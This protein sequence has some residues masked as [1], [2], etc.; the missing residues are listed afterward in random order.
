MKKT[1]LNPAIV[2]FFLLL[3]IAFNFAAPARAGYISLNTALGSNIEGNALK[4]T[5]SSVNKGDKSAF[6]VQA[7]FRVGDKVV[8]A[9]KMA[10]LPV[11]AS[12]QTRTTLPVP[13]TKP[14]TYPL[15]LVM[16]YTDANQYPFSALTAQTFVFRKEAV[17][18]VFGRVNS[19]S[20]FKEG[21]LGF[22]LKN[23]GDREIAASTGLVAPREL[24]VKEEKIKLK[25]GPRSERSAGFTV[26][27]FSAL[28]GSTY[29]VFA[30]TEFED[31]GQHYTSVA[32][33]TIRV[34]E[35]K[36]FLGLSQ[37]IILI[38]LA[39]LVVIFVGAQFVRR[40]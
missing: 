37:N 19:T 18:P 21:R 8:L 22:K 29:Q 34:F 6:N 30:V 3:F 35:E 16:H 40:H 1:K 33:G 15:I 20:F 31:G 28:S 17:S 27:N 9:E 4:V 5:V 39:A 23:L 11:N 13:I 24:T 7:E 32:P 26:N 25:I 36:S 2:Y 12:Y 14:G 38:L 10:E